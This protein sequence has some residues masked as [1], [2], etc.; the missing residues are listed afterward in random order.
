MNRN[1]E[2]D[3]AK[4]LLGISQHNTADDVKKNLKKK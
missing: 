4:H 2:V 3:R 1:Y